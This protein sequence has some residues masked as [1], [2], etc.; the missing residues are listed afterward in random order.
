VEATPGVDRPAGVDGYTASLLELLG[1]ADPFVGQRELM[2]AL[3]PMLLR[4][5][6]APVVDVLEELHVLRRRNL[7]LLESLTPAE[8]DREG[9]HADRGAESVRTFV[10][11]VAGHDLLHRRQIE[12]IKGAL[13][14]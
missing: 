7:R 2:P 9:V 8:L 11:L 6:D 12:R 10:S 5:H 14:L 1:D 3:R 13:G 4:Y